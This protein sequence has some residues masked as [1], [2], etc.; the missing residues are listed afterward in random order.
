MYLRRR[1]VVL[2][3]SLRGSVNWIKHANLESENR[4]CVAVLMDNRPLGD[5]TKVRLIVG[6]RQEQ[7]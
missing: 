5:I 6:P 2:V 4:I 7:S 1:L 3:D